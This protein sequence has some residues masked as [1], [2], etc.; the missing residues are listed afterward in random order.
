[1]A[2]VSVEAR[3]FGPFQHIVL[4]LAKQG[5]VWVGGINKDTK[6]AKS[7]GAGKTHLFKAISWCL[8]GQ[9]IDGY[10]G[11]K[12]I[13]K[14]AKKAQ[15]IISLEGGWKVDRTRT[16][17]TPRVQIIKP[18][19]KPW[20]GDKHDTQAKIIEMVGLDFKAF[21][22]TVL[23]GQNDSARFAN[24]S[25]KD[26]D[27]KDMLHRIMRTEMLR[28]CH[29][30]VSEQAK[31]L[32]AEAADI[33]AEIEQLEARVD[34]HDLEDIQD[35]HDNWEVARNRLINQHRKNAESHKTD[36]VAESGA[37]DTKPLKAQ[38]KKLEKLVEKSAEAADLGEAAAEEMEKLRVDIAHI[39]Q[40]NAA[41]MAAI[42]GYDEDLDQLS[43]DKCLV[44]TSPLGSGIAQ[45]HI[46]GVK[47][48]RAEVIQLNQRLDK[49][50][51]DLTKQLDQLRIALDKHL[52]NERE[53]NRAFREAGQIQGEI[54]DAEAAGERVEHHI[55]LARGY[56]RQA[57]EAKEAVNPHTELLEKAKATIA[58][59]KKQLKKLAKQAKGK[60]EE[61]AHVQFW[62]RGFSGQGLPSFIL[63]SV[64]PYITERA[65]FYLDTLS[66]GDITMRFDT[67]RE[68]KSQKGEWRDEI[69][70]S[71][72]IE[73]VDDSYPP[74]GGQLKKMEVATDLGLMDLVATREG[75]HLDILMLDEVLDGLDEEGRQR[76]LQLLH[77]LRSQRGSIFVISHDSDIEEIFEKAVTVVRE[78]KIATL[79][80]AA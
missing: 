80:L 17:G 12:V 52:Q 10:N 61:L 76:V 36:A 51:A 42:Q 59:H 8:Y 11:D 56:L 53:G 39:D 28:D 18:D 60:A 57:K 7:N 22:N 75:V 71:W 21:K 78:N 29:K 19:G 15:V 72:E 55:E 48:E 73:G 34:E 2:L 3:D 9:S 24:P 41:A 43:G 74:S 49:E 1:M 46:K 26:S 23:Y 30:R 66:D 27:R 47:H 64:M 31:A 50:S 4:Q 13:R 38:I 5:L 62:V 77:N 63:D 44:C 54:A 20:K 37:V 33:D 79:E 68:L 32:K 67:Q 65:N 45:K 6:A 58:K 14:G 40:G 25:T 16:K 69:N 70:I 35:H